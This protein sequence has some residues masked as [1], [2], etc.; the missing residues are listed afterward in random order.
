MEI[1]NYIL[2][3]F[4]FI[5][6]QLFT[7]SYDLTGNYGIAILLLS[8]GI[9]LLLLPV[10]IY[11]E[12]SKKKDDIVKNK[13]QPLIDEIKRVYRGQERYYYI[14]T[15]NRQ[16]NYSSLKALI[17]ILSLLIQIPFFIAAYQFLEDFAPLKDIDFL[18]IS[19]LSQPD[20]LFGIVNILP[21]IM[22]IVN[23]L[24]AYYYTR[25]GNKTELKQML[26]LAAVFLVL[27]FNLP[28]GL[29]LYWTMNNIFSFLRLFITN[30]EVFRK[31][32]IST[33]NTK[34]FSNYK[35]IFPQLKQVFIYS[36]IAL[37][38]FQIYWAFNYNF[39]DIIL[40]LFAAVAISF[41]FSL[42]VSL[43]ILLWKKYKD[44]IISIEVK[45]IVYFTL[46]FLSIYFNLAAKYYFTGESSELSILAIMSILPLQLIGYLY[47]YRSRNRIKLFNII[48]IIL[49]LLITLQIINLFSIFAADSISFS[50]LGLSIITRESSSLAF[51]DTGM[52][53]SFITLIYYFKYNFS[54]NLIK[55]KASLPIYV[56]SVLY[57]TGLVFYWNPL[58][59]FSSFPDNFGFAGIDILK[60]NFPL[61]SVSIIVSLILF[62]VLSGKIK[63]FLVVFTLLIAVISF[64][65]SSI[66]PINLGTLQMHR[67][68]NI[69]NLA[70]PFY[71]FIL[72]AGLLILV[73]I[74]VK[75]VLKQINYSK[76]IIGLIL[77]NTITI[78]QSVYL[79]FKA[80]SFFS[81][82]I[83]SSETQEYKN[84]EKSY[85][86]MKGE[87]NYIS[88][89]KNKENVVV[90]VLDMFQGWYLRQI[91]IDNPEFS[92]TLSGFKWYPNSISISN[93]T[94]VTAPS[95]LL[96][97]NYT[98]DL[99]NKDS[100]HTLSEKIASVNDILR[101]RVQSD[102]KLFISNKIPY[103]KSDVSKNDSY[104]PVWDDKWNNI[105][106]IL[107]IG[108]NRELEYTLLWQ[109]SFFYSLP[110]FIKPRIYNNGKWLLAKRES[111]ENNKL[112]E[113]Y[114]LL[115]V[116]PYIS[117]TYSDKGSVTYLWFKA[118]HFPWDIVDDN[119]NLISNVTPYRNNE[120]A[121][122]RI[123]LWLQWMKNNNVYDNTK[124]IIS[125]DHG[126]RNTEINDTIMYENPFV[127]KISEKVSLAELLDFTPLMMVKDY[128]SKG[129][130]T[131]NS[132]LLSNIDIYDIAF[133]KNNISNNDSII[134]HSLEAYLVSWK[135]KAS[136]YKIPILKK[137]K[138]D[139]NVFYLDNWTRLK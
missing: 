110:L 87:N 1:F 98:P 113:H 104:I 88:F 122:Q 16:H 20:G 62:F 126:I 59:V 52:L 101:E 76:I 31:K 37:S 99:L 25:N 46:L 95:L 74:I 14:K 13:M 65:Y 50:L 40:R 86:G 102:S 124:I 29:V 93:Y 27:L 9:S 132:K 90:I 49:F 89:S 138:V 18:F 41:V 103:S 118:T 63:R 82:E 114:N 42:L 94:S 17:P 107:N 115:R 133:N 81:T 73:F 139:N 23:I 72:E 120:W 116:L 7:F 105:K 39:D 28:A 100:L 15:I 67:F 108:V 58:T 35:S 92:N 96:G 53:F 128:N 121:M 119:S 112:T 3:P 11:I 60:T 83:V 45:P 80:N 36:A 106:P 48:S 21:I 135:L 55:E 54:N 32:E 91:L 22:T 134:N 66:I 84:R 6:E 127:P 77:L 24:T 111:N 38:F 5:I 69:S 71:Y 129:I 8:F 47:F 97:E 26:V 33:E 68:S 51:A 109:N 61:F 30:P 75:E 125:S 57:V 4:I 12:K 79:T 56:L 2:A 10:F 70:K 34:L 137:Y 130:I 43:I 131:E 85:N 78:S 19:D 123:A 117:N 64:I 44:Q 136:Q